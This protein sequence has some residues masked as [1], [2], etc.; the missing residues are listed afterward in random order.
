MWHA[1]DGWSNGHGIS[2]VFIIVCLI[3]PACPH[4]HGELAP[5]HPA[6][7]TS[8]ISAG[9]VLQG[10]G[11][12]FSRTS[13]LIPPDDRPG[14][15]QSQRDLPSESCALLDFVCCVWAL[16]FITGMVPLP[17]SEWTRPCGPLRCPPTADWLG[18]SSARTIVG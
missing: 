17:S 18:D 10:A 7:D 6:N 4:Q 15:S 8:G 9:G 5:L 2:K 14:S 11:I 16:W 12:I 13:G 1:R 3:A